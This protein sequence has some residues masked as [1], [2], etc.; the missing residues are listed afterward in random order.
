[1]ADIEDYTDLQVYSHE[2]ATRGKQDQI[3]AL[4][5]QMVELLTTLDANI[6]DYTA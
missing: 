2:P 5:T 3:I 4:L 1:M 6:D